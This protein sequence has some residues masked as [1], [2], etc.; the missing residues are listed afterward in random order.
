MAKRRRPTRRRRRPIIALPFNVEI[1]LSTPIDN[2]INVVSIVGVLEEDFYCVSVDIQIVME[3]MTALEGPHRFGLAHGD[4]SVAEIAE[5][6]DVTILGPDQ[7]I[8]QERRRRLVRTI[9]KLPGQVPNEVM[10]DGKEIRVPVRWTIGD[11]EVFNLWHRNVSGATLTTG[12]AVIAEGRL[13]GR[14]LR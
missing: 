4:Y 12:A 2:E 9:G 6:L 5:H 13:Y 11:G 3:N 8:E 7:K 1:G 14:W 10:N